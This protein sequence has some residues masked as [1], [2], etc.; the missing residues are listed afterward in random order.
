MTLHTFGS[1][2]CRPFYRIACLDLDAVRAQVSKYYVKS[3][4]IDNPQAFSRDTQAN[5]AVLG[6]TPEA[7]GMQIR[8]EATTRS[9]IRVRNVV[10]GDRALAGN[11][12]YSGHREPR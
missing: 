11:L 2:L 5:P 3:F 4:L 1:T 8:K 6:F 12:T 7:T 9:V 10:T